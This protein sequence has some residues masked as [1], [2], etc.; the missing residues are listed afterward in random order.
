MKYN[1][2]TINDDNNYLLID[3]QD[4]HSSYLFKDYLAIAFK[5]KFKALIVFTIVVA[6]TALMTFRSPPL[7]EAKTALLIKIGREYLNHSELGENRPVLSIRQEELTNSEIQILTNR[8]SVKKAISAIGLER[9]YPNLVKGS[10]PDK[11][12]LEEA[13]RRFE[14]AL[15]VDA[16]KKSSVVWVSFRHEDPQIAAQTVN[17]LVELFKEKHLEAYSNPKSP[18]LEKQLEAYR[19]KLKESETSLQSYKQKNAI[20]QIDEQR[21][22]LL[23]QRA[24][25][26]HLLKVSEHSSR[27]LQK[28][29]VH[30]KNQIQTLGSSPNR[31]TNSERDRIVVDANARLLTLQLQE[32]ELLEKYKEDNY[33]VVNARKEK[34]T[35]EKFIKEQEE[36]TY[37]KV[38]TG[39]PIFQT[40]EMDLI[41]AETDYNAQK[42]KMSA[43]RQQL[44]QLDQKVRS[45]DFSDKELQELKRDQMIN[46]KNYQTYHGKA[47]EE[48]ISEDMDRLKLANISIIQDA[49]VPD[50]PLSRHRK[51]FLLLGMLGGAVVAFAY[52]IFSEAA[53]Q[54]FASPR[55]VERQLGLPV[56]ATI[57]EE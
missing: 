56:L 35:V 7:Y 28:R 46:E 33:L 40:V 55:A 39:N 36:N 1:R 5:H 24:D 8:G 21:S 54:T 37:A 18:F 43:L 17:T 57:N 49:T 6:V 2:S 15:R 30:L 41:K 16:V 45:L 13:A 14:K 27:E 22:L 3:D 38:R 50:R 53:A 52:A 12:P 31:Y 44:A 32:Q 10:T 20:F 25:L 26:D 51:L 48:R 34:A 23:K 4:N 29:I 47:E 19:A 9:I 11:D 42:G